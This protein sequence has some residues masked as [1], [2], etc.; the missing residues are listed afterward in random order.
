MSR[1]AEYTVEDDY[2]LYDGGGGVDQP[3]IIVTPCKQQQ[4]S[5]ASDSTNS[6]I[7]ERPR[8]PRPPMP[9]EC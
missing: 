7:G 9:G 1:L 5:L 3:T 2:E 8:T 6:R 4:Q